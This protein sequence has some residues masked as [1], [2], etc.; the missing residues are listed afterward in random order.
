MAAPLPV[1]CLA[2]AS[3]RRRAL[4]QQI[5]V[6]H[7]ALRA[8]VDETPQPGELPRAYVA[9]IA[10]AKARAIRARDATLPVLGADT[11]VVVDGVM[12]GKPANREAGLAMLASL[13]GRVHEVLSAVA[14]ADVRG[15][16]VAIS[17]SAVR[18]RALSAQEC[19]DYWDSGEPRDKAGGYAI[20]GLAA[21]FIAA[22]DGSYS[23][24]MGLPLFETAAL[25]LAAGVPYGRVLP[26]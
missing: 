21:A 25:L 17:V 15:M 3:P 19:R 16:A 11:T 18:F 23:G 20:Q 9:R 10:A 22:L 24:V 5:G 7:V 1:L 26:P 6:A 14:L 2:S 12:F 4:L 8:D 13:S